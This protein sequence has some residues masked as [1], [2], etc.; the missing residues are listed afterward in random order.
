MLSS[1]STDLEMSTFL[2]R[3]RLR[4]ARE[5]LGLTQH[6]LAKACGLSINQIN[7][8]ENGTTEPS[9][10]ALA[11]VAHKLDVSI[12]YL[13]GLTD[14]PHNYPALD[15]RPDERKLLEAYTTGDSATV[16]Q[17]L[18]DRLRLLEGQNS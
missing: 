14:I 4:A 6:E 10:S 8:Y 1:D 17:L 5:K 13:L 18:S 11:A 15:L 7:R 3:D 2:R 9:A 16:V 12:D